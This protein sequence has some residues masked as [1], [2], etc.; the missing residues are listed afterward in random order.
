MLYF[1][2]LALLRGASS[3]RALTCN[4]SEDS[5]RLSMAAMDVTRTSIRNI[6]VSSEKNLEFVDICT[7]FFLFVP[8]LPPTPSLMLGSFGFAF[9]LLLC[10]T[11]CLASCSEGVVVR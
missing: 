10:C 3:L 4:D 1:N 7:S 5:G 8:N 9:E 6:F 11:R 2:A